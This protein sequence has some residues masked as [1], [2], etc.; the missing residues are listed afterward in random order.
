MYRTFSNGTA[1]IETASSSSGWDQKLNQIPWS[2]AVEDSMLKSSAST[3]KNSVE[4]LSATL[5]FL[6]RLLFLSSGDKTYSI[7]LRLWLIFC[8]HSQ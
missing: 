2:V 6:M 1:A 4:C 7:L 3:E 5:N 8:S